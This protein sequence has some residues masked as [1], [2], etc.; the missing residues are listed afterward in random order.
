MNICLF[1]QEEIN[2]P[3]NINDDRAQHILKIL[4]KKEGDTFAAGIINGMAGDAKILSIK[5]L[6][7]TNEKGKSF[8]EGEIVFSFTPQ[9]DGKLLY[10][11]KMII[12]FPRPIQLKRLL[13]DMAG[14]G[15][16]EVHL[17]GTELGEKSY[18]D[19]DLAT[20]DSGNKMLL[21]GTEQAAS[22]HSPKLFRHNSLKECLAFIDENS[23]DDNCKNTKQALL[24]LDNVEP[25]QSL[26][27][28]LE[29]NPLKQNEHIIQAVA[30]IGSERG[31]TKSERQLLYANGYKL[32]SMGCRVFRTETAATVAASLILSSMHVLN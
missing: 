26:T 17:T 14:L 25:K 6:T 9:T 4:H 2:S 15:V 11:L 16:C 8:E 1:T 18:L 31:W 29:N 10:P 22:T 12:G 28:F 27:D 24:A 21:E 30:A 20:T 13:R 32:L 3:L 19:S 23:N 5:K 7:V